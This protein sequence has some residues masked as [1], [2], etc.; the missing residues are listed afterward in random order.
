M[1]ASINAAHAII[2]ASRVAQGVWQRYSRGGGSGPGRHLSGGGG[3]ANSIP[4]SHG[5][6]Y[7]FAR[8][9][10]DAAVVAAHVVIQ[11]PQSVVAKV[12]LEDVRVALDVLRDPAV[13]TGRGRG[14]SRGGGG[15]QGCP[16]EAVTIVE[17][18]LKKAEM[19]KRN[20]VVPVVVAGVKRKHEEVEVEQQQQHVMRGFLLPYVGPGVAAGGAGP[21]AAAES[22]SSVS[23]VM[24]TTPVNG[25]VQGSPRTKFFDKGGLFTSE[26]HHSH[27]H[28]HH[29]QGLGHRVPGPAG[30]ST[31]STSTRERD[32]ERK[33][34]PPPSVGIRSRPTACTG[35][36]TPVGSIDLQ[37]P[38]GG[39]GPGRRQARSVT[40]S[41]P[42]AAAESGGGLYGR[43][44]TSMGNGEESSSSPASVSAV[45][46]SSGGGGGG[47]GEFTL[48]APYGMGDGRTHLVDICVSPSTPRFASLSQPPSQTQPQ[49]QPPQAQQPPPPPPPP[50]PS[51]PQGYPSFQPPSGNNTACATPQ[52]QQQQHAHAHASAMYDSGAYASEARRPPSGPASFYVPYQP[53]P[54]PPPQQQQSQQQQQQQHGQQ[55]Q[56][57]QGRPNTFR[58]M[59]GHGH[60]A[61]AQQQLPPPPPSQQQQ[62]QQQHLDMMGILPSQ[63]V[64]DTSD[65]GGGVTKREEG[66]TGTGTGTADGRRGGGEG[67]PH[68]HPAGQSPFATAAAGEGWSS[69]GVVTRFAG[70]APWDTGYSY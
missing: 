50:P 4:S 56:P 9:L 1:T 59:S 26:N 47:G 7:P 23:S 40:N 64:M 25:H 67:Q 53:P 10:F 33:Y 36:G 41:Q 34:P 66:G 45:V 19:A 37:P 12:A 39:P 8:Q 51:Q 58:G 46:Q 31:T 24:P 62:Q 48:S 68:T 5:V 70:Q 60:I 11:A 57:P 55:P 21:S 27:H 20:Y 38:V 22:P 44:T 3:G 17:M 54:P 30:V 32:K 35:V 42:V 65:M 6:F 43:R 61:A 28:N 52:Q 29:H 14:A 2:H 16:S 49:A 15:V 18:M 63:N 13:A 69:S